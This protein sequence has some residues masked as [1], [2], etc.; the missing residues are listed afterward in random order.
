VNAKFTSVCQAAL[1]K[2]LFSKIPEVRLECK[3]QIF[4]GKLCV[5]ILADF[6]F[7][8]VCFISDN[9]IAGSF[10]LVFRSLNFLPQFRLLAFAPLGHRFLSF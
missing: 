3:P 5:L 10:G 1:D 2:V 9:Y 6:Q 4:T 7:Q 8:V